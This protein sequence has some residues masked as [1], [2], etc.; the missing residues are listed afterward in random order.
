MYVYTL[1]VASVAGSTSRRFSLRKNLAQLTPGHCVQRVISP[2]S[3]E[4]KPSGKFWG[5]GEYPAW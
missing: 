2:I 5:H 3:G 1:Y 4:E